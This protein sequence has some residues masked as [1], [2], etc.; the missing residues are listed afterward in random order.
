MK[1]KIALICL[2]FGGLFLPSTSVIAR[3]NKIK[4]IDMEKIRSNNY[5]RFVEHVFWYSKEVMESKKISKELIPADMQKFKD[6]LKKVLKSEYL[7]SE[8]VIDSNAV[9]IENLRDANDYILLEYNRNKR[10]IQIQDGKALYISIFP[11]DYLKIEQSDMAEYVKSVALQ[12]MNLPKS[13]EKGKERHVFVSPLDIGDSKCGCIFYEANCDPLQLW[14]SYFGWWSDGKNVLF[15]IGK[16][17]LN[18]E[19][20]SRRAGP[21]EN[22]KAP[23]KFK[24]DGKPPK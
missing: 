9:A 16:T 5:T 8:T 18:G 15:Q 23:R 14:Y 20:L 7:L 22:I 6:I 4:S 3:E 13:D 12:I 17:P 24:K 2:V 19:D 11:D 21:P 1:D 10:K